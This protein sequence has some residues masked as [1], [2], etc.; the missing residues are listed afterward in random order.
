M[1]VNGM[2]AKRLTILLVAAVFTLG[3]VG[4]SFSAQEVKGTILKIEGVSLTILDGTGKK[5]TVRVDEPE[6][7]SGLKAG[8]RV[9]VKDGKVTKLRG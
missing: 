9:S 4:V 8:D 7:C 1:E 3:V 5:V 2:T 6:M